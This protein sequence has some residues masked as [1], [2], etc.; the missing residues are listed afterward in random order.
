MEERKSTESPQSHVRLGFLF[1]DEVSKKIQQLAHY[2]G[3]TPHQ[4][5]EE[6]VETMYMAYTHTRENS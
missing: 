3:L 1:G 6:A 5:M 2:Q 4:L